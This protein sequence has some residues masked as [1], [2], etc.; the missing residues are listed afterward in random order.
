M[1]WKTPHSYPLHEVQ[2]CDDCQVGEAAR[3]FWHKRAAQLHMDRLATLFTQA[4]IPH[5]FLEI[6]LAT[7]SQIAGD[8][9]EKQQAIQACEQMIEHGFVVQRGKHR[10]GL[11]LT[12]PY[13]VGKTGL[14]TCVL[15]HW[16]DQGKVGLWIE[17]YDFIS[18]IQGGYGDGTAKERMEAARTAEWLLLDDVGDAE[19]QGPETTDRQRIL[20]QLVNFRHNHNLPILMTTNLSLSGLAQQFGQRTVERIIESCAVVSIAG[21]NLRMRKAN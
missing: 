9:K 7:F 3:Q 18:E 15:S 21:A 16:L 12:G 10:A 20:Y 6:S 2:F 1:G 17:F 13:G 5:R 4:G 19:R 8:D 14:L 11:V